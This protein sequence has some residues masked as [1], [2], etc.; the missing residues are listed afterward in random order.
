MSK[1]FDA[2]TAPRV[3]ALLLDALKD[4][5]EALRES[6]GDLDSIVRPNTISFTNAITA[7][8]RCKR[9]DSAERASALLD[10]MHSLYED[11]WDF[12]R[13]NRVTYNSV[14]TAWSRSRERG[15]AARVEDLMHALFAFYNQEGGPEDLKPDGR[16]FNSAIIAVARSRGKNILCAVSIKRPSHRHHDQI[17]QGMR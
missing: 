7:W 15:R 8:A 3:E 10:R 1:E 16:S 13:P 2:T 9:E 14:I 5:Q 17:R 6:A 11:G 4:Y 12:V